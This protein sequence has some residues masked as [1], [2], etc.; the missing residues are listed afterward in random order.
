MQEKLQRK[1]SEIIFQEWGLSGKFWFGFS[2]TSWQIPDSQEIYHTVWQISQFA[3]LIYTPRSYIKTY[4]VMHLPNGRTPES[5]AAHTFL[6]EALA[7]MAWNYI[8][9]PDTLEVGGFTKDQFKSAALRHDIAEGIFGDKADDG[10]RDEVAKKAN[11][12]AYHL[13]FSE[14]FP[15][16]ERDDAEKVNQ[17]LAQME[18]KSSELGRLLFLADKLSAILVVLHGNVA[19]DRAML[20]INDPNLSERDKKEMELCD[21]IIEKGGETFCLASEMWTIDFL[22]MREFTKYDDYGYFTA[23]LV[24]Y[25]LYCRNGKWY[26]WREKDY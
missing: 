25:T 19:G 24:M 14:H 22:K 7:G 4:N 3:Q 5:V 15:E 9:G 11:E 16:Q 18:E 6:M 26:E 12:R 2:A 17:L 10:N 23:L 1:Y 8:Y 13:K 20:N 21:E